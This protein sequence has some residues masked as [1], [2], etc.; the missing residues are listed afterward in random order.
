MTNA[1]NS[2]KQKIESF[3]GNLSDYIYDN[4]IRVIIAILCI[5]IALGTQLRYVTLNTSTEG[6]LHKDSKELIKYN[7]FVSQFGK[8]DRVIITIQSDNVLDKD[9]LKKLQKLHKQLKDNTPYLN[10]ITSLINARN[11]Y[12]TKDSL[13]VD[14]LFEEI[15]TNKQEFEHKKKLAKSNAFLDNLIINKDATLTSI[16]IEPIAYST[17]NQD[18]KSTSND[19]GGFDDG[20]T[21]DSDSANTNEQKDDRVLLSDEENTK[22]VNKIVQITNEYNDDNFKILVAGSS[23]V[24]S[25]LKTGMKHDMMLFTRLTILVIAVTLAFLFLRI[26]G[27]VLPLIAVGLT[28]VVTISLMGLTRTP[29]SMVTQIMPSFLLA[30][31]VGGAIHVLAIFFKQFDTT[32]DKKASLRY[33]MGHSALAIIMTTLTT[34]AGLWSF[35]FS[36]V[37]PIADLGKFASVGVI[38]GLLFTIVLIPAVLSLIRLKPKD[39]KTYNDDKAHTLMDK[40]LLNIADASVKYYKQILLVSFVAIILAIAV[41]SKIKFSHNPT[42]WLD[43]NSPVRISTTLIDAKMGGSS[44]LEMILDTKKENGLYEP[45]VL[46]AIDEFSKKAL[47]IKDEHY[48]V[49]KVMSIIDILKESNKA[50]HA[51]DENYYKIPDD[52]KLIAQELFLFSNSGSDDME[53]FVDSGFSKARITLK[54]PNMDAI[55]YNDLLGEVNKAINEEG[56]AYE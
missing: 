28:I 54:L 13:I 32:K 52:K 41:A 10:D 5:V 16:I 46:K 49:T 53:K 26:S 50:L 47:L 29:L 33:A 20:F 42:L 17:L 6:F 2:Y 22:M 21:D 34:A 27:V 15:P 3:F 45:K 39:I 12:G 4:P 24:T 56:I 44:T 40:I 23:V 38:L 9:F 43:E 8:D 19:E 7:E 36:S 18:K 25:D 37:A 14:D 51:N 35:S 55:Y 1:L 30:V 11:T 31:I 48:K